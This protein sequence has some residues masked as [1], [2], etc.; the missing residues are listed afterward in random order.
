VASGI[1]GS[2]AER[3][4]GR[5]D[6]ILVAKGQVIRFQGAYADNRKIASVVA[7][8]RVGGRRRRSWSGLNLNL[9][10]PPQLPAGGAS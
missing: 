8:V 6:F 7:Q 10:A 3:L 9:T 4:L 5:G 2:S 1:A